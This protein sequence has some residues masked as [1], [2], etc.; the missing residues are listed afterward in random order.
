MPDKYL[1]LFT[2]GGQTY[3]YNGKEQLIRVQDYKGTIYRDAAASETNLEWYKSRA[4]RFSDA[5]DNFDTRNKIDEQSNLL[6]NSNKTTILNYQDTGR[7]ELVDGRNE[8]LITKMDSRTSDFKV[9]L[10]Y[11]D[12]KPSDVS[13]EYELN[14]DGSIKMNGN[15][16]YA[17]K[18]EQHKNY[19]RN[20]DFGIV[21]RARQV[22]KLD[23]DV[24]NVKITLA[25]GMVLMNAKIVEKDGKKTFE[26][27]VKSAVYI[28]K[29]PQANGQVKFELDNEIIQG[30]HVEIQYALTITN[31]SEKDYKDRNFYLYGYR[32]DNEDNIVTLRTD[33][34][35]DYL[36]NKVSFDV[37][38]EGNTIGEVIQQEAQKKGL[39]TNQGLLDDTNDIRN[40]LNRTQRVLMIDKNLATSL[41]KELRPNDT[42]KTG[43]SV[44]KLLSNVSKNEDSS[45]D[46]SAE[47]VQTV[48]SWGSPLITI[49]GNYIASNAETS[50]Y[51]NDDA[52]TVI[53]VPP[54]GL[55]RNYVAYII[56]SISILGVFV[57]GIILIKKFILK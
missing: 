33:K 11:D 39:I 26:N 15:G 54:T 7:L 52:E 18:K 55:N 25:N 36:D 4:Q 12:T 44:S 43:F 49:P 40:L 10:E 8:N 37:K 5:K 9:N 23:K 29:S 2:W 3:T 32:P 16:I 28:P 27:D 1:V 17:I 24:T 14:P 50:D 46:N 6:K 20:V 31:I 35:I 51:D 19:L 34:I 41:D 45:F 42:V 53:I 38:A 57:S 56:V 22:L 48:K 21:E 13:D 47:I 30:A